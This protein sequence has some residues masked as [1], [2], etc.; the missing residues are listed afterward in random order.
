MKPTHLLSLY[1]A[2]LRADA[3]VTDADEVTRIGPLLASTFIT[4]RRGFVSYPHFAMDGAELN[5]LI[6]SVLEHFK[7]DA[8]V[9]E[10][11]WKTRGHDELPDLLQRLND[12][13]FVEEE[14]ETVMAGDVEAMIA[15]DP[16]LPDSYSL[17]LIADERSLR[18]AEAL[19]G[20]VFGDSAERSRRQ[21]DELV[22]RMREDQESFEMWAVRDDEGRVVCSGRVDF[23]NGTDFATLWGGACES[24][25]QGRGLYR[26]IV[27]ARARSAVCRG[28]RFVQVDCTAYSRPILQRAG[29][30]AITTTTPT[31]WRRP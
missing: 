1:D 18:E 25:H 21:A 9:D 2:Q 29:L 20:Q 3:E 6:D 16:G 7:A 10:V 11:E 26:A 28:K 31:L 4:R 15:A 19:A 23:V 22:Q 13:G 14:I 8:R 27:A 5:G 24:R 30:T 17:E 12:R